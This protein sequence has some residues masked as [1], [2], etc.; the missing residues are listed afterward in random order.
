MPYGQ[1]VS[2]PP[3]SGKTTYTR[4]LHEFLTLLKRRPHIV[5]FDPGADPSTF[6]GSSSGVGD[7]PSS[8]PPPPPPPPSF[9][10]RALVDINSV[11][12]KG[13][14]PNGALQWS[15]DYLE[16]NAGAALG[17]MKAAVV[18]AERRR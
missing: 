16:R 14:G 9:D 7:G 2:G 18:E 4:G 6:G 5:N 3:G 13:L 8:P 12:S 10:V 11:M 17:R 15:F 1:I